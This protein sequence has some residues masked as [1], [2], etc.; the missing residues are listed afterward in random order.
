MLE[1]ML[2]I[3]GL[4]KYF[5]GLSAV[6]DVD[7]S[8]EPGDLLGLIGPN[9]A[10][11]T[12]FFNLVTGYLRPT[13][14]RVIFEGKDI[15]KKKPHIVAARGIVR[16]F[17]ATNIY[18]DFTVL[19]N[20]VVACHLKPRVNFWET[21]LHTR[22]GRRKEADILKRSHE[23]LGLVGLEYMANDVAGAL[24]HGHK[25][26][27]GIAIALAAEPKLLLLDEPFSGMNAEEVTEAMQLI[28]K[29]SQ[30]GMTILLIEH[31]MRAAMNLSKR[32]VVLNFGKKIA[33]G[34]PE[35]VRNNPEVIKAYLGAGEHA[36]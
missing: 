31:N 24:A 21:V 19:E 25:R 3:E 34:T 2:E 15:T 14:G 5:G 36:A 6:N 17:Q 23:I 13:K 1:H 10:G 9:G 20:V 18:P 28:R 30:S 32:I 33:E 16:T 7:I 11:K 12:T 26:I 29:I 35:E 27:L 22:G 4:T 8:M